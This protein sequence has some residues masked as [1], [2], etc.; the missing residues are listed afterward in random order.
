VENGSYAGFTS[1]EPRQPA[2][3]GKGNAEPETQQLLCWGL[4]AKTAYTPFGG[5]FK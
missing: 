2:L 4:T 3:R 5:V 1:R